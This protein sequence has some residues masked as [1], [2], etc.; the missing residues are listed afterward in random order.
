MDMKEKLQEIVQISGEKHASPKLVYLLGVLGICSVI[1]AGWLYFSDS[2]A[3]SA[4]E[5]ANQDIQISSE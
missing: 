1:L 4:A 5:R 2:T 3:S